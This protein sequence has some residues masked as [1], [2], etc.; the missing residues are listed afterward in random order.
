MTHGGV[1]ANTKFALLTKHFC[2]AKKFLLIE[3][4]RN[5]SS[6]SDSQQFT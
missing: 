6:L 5:I 3:V 1:D 4:K 2:A